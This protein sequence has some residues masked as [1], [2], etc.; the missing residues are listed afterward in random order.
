MTNQVSEA[1]AAIVDYAVQHGAKS[2][3]DLEGCWEA[4]VGEWFF[5]LNGHG[6]ATT[7]SRGADVEPYGVYLEFNG[8]PAG[9]LN[10]HS[11]LM[12]AGAAANEDTLIAALR[13]ATS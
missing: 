7:C 11:G 6:E 10:A 1:F 13:E 4:T 12:A 5:A 2:I 3:K 9:T 8:W